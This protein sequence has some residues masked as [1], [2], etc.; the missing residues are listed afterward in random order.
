MVGDEGV[1]G[2]QCV[3]GDE[4]E[5]EGVGKGRRRKRGVLRTGCRPRCGEWEGSGLLLVGCGREQKSRI[6]GVYCLAVPAAY[7][8]CV[9]GGEG[10]GGGGGG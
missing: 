9:C 7:K 10:R 4:D 2:I 5:G 8:V 1:K 3:Q 6:M